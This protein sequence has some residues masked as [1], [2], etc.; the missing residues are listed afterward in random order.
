MSV[1]PFHVNRNKSLGA[2]LE[3]TRE[4]QSF[5]TRGSMAPSHELGYKD[6]PEIVYSW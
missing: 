6:L 3:L 2:Q 1:I 5:E 4:N